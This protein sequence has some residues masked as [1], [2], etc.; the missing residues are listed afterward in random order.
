MQVKQIDGQNSQEFKNVEVSDLECASYHNN[1]RFLHSNPKVIETADD[2][3]NTYVMVDP[4]GRFVGNS[5]GVYT[6]SSPILEVGA[7]AAYEEM[8]YD[9]EGFIR[10]G[11][12]YR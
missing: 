5:N 6:Y 7:G 10:R 11:G 4:S 2:M 3:T 8:D 1:M 9:Y 12:Y